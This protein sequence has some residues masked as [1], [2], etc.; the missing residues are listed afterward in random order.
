[1]AQS[2]SNVLI[3]LVFSTKGRAPVLNSEV[4]SRLHA[5]LGRVLRTLGCPPLIVGGVEDHVHLLFQLGRTTH[6]ATAVETLKTS[7]SKWLKAEHDIRHFAWQGGYGAFSISHGDVGRVCR[8]IEAQEEHHS[9]RSFQEELRELL[10]LAGIEF[11]E[12]YLWD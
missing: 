5:Y 11:D 6:L 7:S 12:R 8:Y 9:K 2:L 4:R 1:M 3:H 10:G